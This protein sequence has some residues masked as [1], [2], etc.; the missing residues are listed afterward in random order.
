M[1]RLSAVEAMPAAAKAPMSAMKRSVQRLMRLNGEL[2]EYHR[3]E[4]GKLRLR[5]REVDIVALLRD[6][7]DNFRIAAESKELGFHF[8]PFTNSLTLAVDADKIDKIVF[9]LLSN[10][11]KY[12]PRHGSV[13][14]TLRCNDEKRLEI[15]VA[16]TGVGID[17]DRQEKLFERFSQGN[18][19]ADSMGI[20]M[21]LTWGLV[22][23]HKGTMRYEDNPGGGSVFVVTLPMDKGAYNAGDFVV[24]GEAVCPQK[25]GSEV[26]YTEMTAQPMNDIKVLVV[27]DDDDV[28]DFIRQELSR[29]FTVQTAI[30][31]REALDMIAAEVP[32][33]VISDIRMPIMDGLTLLKKIRADGN[34]FDLPVIMLTA[35]SSEEKQL[36][37]LEYGADAYI[38]KPFNARMLCATCASL[39]NR[40][41]KV[42]EQLAGKARNQAAAQPSE[43]AKDA[44]TPQTADTAG[45]EEAATTVILTS[46]SDK[47]FILQLERMV[48]GRMADANLSV[49]DLTA[50]FRMGR[51]KFYERVKSTTGKTPNCYIR[52]CRMEAARRLLED[53]SLTVA[54]VAYKVGF[55]DPF[56]FGTC[57]K[58]QYGVTP[59]K[60]RKGGRP[61]A[62]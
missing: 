1:D 26:P 58:R 40:H 34:L 61:A 42:M 50:M 45:A 30:N 31:G 32:S 52:D 18:V 7:A 56:Y 53:E 54:E 41:R 10:A 46:E 57:F 4:H 2:M 27:E 33:L 5:L 6:I 43:A 15:R 3:M 12:T 17:K 9:N 59:S 49:D 48:S 13:M 35:F 11:F 19:A 28:R 36:K 14:M 38:H 39:I 60:Y 21:N 44:D 16:D 29:L 8:T 55:S 24:D 25:Q 20:G 47:K 37:G 22:N 23:A 62:E 51:S